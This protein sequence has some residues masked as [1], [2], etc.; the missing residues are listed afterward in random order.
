MKPRPLLLLPLLP[1][2]ASDFISAL[3]CF[4]FLA[5]LAGLTFVVYMIISAAKLDDM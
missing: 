5:F 3:S 2:P 1:I 4:G